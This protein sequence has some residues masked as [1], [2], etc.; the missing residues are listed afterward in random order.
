MVLGLVIN[1]QTSCCNTSSTKNCNSKTEQIIE[2][3]SYRVE[4]NCG[5]CKTRIEKAAL[6]IKGVKTADWNQTTKILNLTFKKGV[7][8]DEILQAVANVGHDNEKFKA[9]ERVYNNLHACCKYRD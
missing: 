5:L 8:T 7:N 2:K 1:A 6:N 3:T 9:S 4:G